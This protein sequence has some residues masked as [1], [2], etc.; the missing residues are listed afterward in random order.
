MEWLNGWGGWLL[1][2]F[3]LLM[4]ELLIAGVFII[5]WGIAAV[6]IAVVS[7]LFPALSF[8]VQAVAFA[9]LAMA[10]S[11]IWWKYQHQKDRL[12]DSQTSLNSREHHLIGSKGVVVEQLDNGILRGK[13]GDTT[14]KIAGD[15]LN[16]QD[17]VEVIKVEGITLIVRKI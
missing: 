5:W 7:A 12:E 1:V 11:L 4:L 6:I 15:N 3:G 16:L 14:W 10:S 17:T 13:F 9:L 8:A 2:G